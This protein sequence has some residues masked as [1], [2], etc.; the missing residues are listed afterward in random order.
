LRELLELLVLRLLRQS[1]SI[2]LVNSALQVF[3]Q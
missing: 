3:F 1:H 2:S